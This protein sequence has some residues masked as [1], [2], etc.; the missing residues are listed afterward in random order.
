MYSMVES[1]PRMH[2]VLSSTAYTAKR[3]NKSKEI[4]HCLFQDPPP[5]PLFLSLFTG[6][7]S[8]SFHTWVS[9]GLLLDSMKLLSDL[10]YKI[11]ISLLCSPCQILWFWNWSAVACSYNLLTFIAVWI[12]TPRQIFLYIND[13]FLSINLKK[14]NWH[15][16]DQAKRQWRVFLVALQKEHAHSFPNL[17]QCA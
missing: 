1:L 15:A 6:N 11:C 10:H 12:L 5:S 2:K 9:L 3:R 8:I 17:H 7:H 14:K 4:E 16:K 13:Y